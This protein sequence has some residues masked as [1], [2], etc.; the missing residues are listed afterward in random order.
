MYQQQHDKFLTMYRN[1]NWTG[2]E[3]FAH[4]LKDNWLEMS[5]YYNVMIDRIDEYRKNPPGEEWD[6]VY[7]ATTK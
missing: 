2:A 7:R 6:G 3:K 5:D 4:D 1:Q